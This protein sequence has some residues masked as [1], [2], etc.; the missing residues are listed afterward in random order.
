MT[1]LIHTILNEHQN[2]LA[3]SDIGVIT[4][5]NGQKTLLKNLLSST[6]PAIEGVEVNTVDG[7]QGREKRVI[8]FSAV[9]SNKGK[10]VGFL[11]DGRRM[12]VALTRAKDALIVVADT[13]TVGGGDRKWGQF[14]S[15]VESNT[16]TN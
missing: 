1:T 15:W 5:Y 9:R 6:Q 8:I 4:P 11:S 3:P 2:T 13:T 10:K 12:N 7:F 14:F 16:N